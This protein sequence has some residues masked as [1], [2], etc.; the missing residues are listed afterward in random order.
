[1][2]RSQAVFFA[3]DVVSRP[4]CPVRLRPV[5]LAFPLTGDRP[6]P[7]PYGRFFFPA[8][9]PAGELSDRLVLGV[10]A[11]RAPG[12][13]V[14]PRW[15]S[16]SCSW[17]PGRGRSRAG[18]GALGDPSRDR[19]AGGSGAIAIL[20]PH[21][22]GVGYEATDL[23]PARAAQKPRPPG[24]PDRGEDGGHRPSSLGFGFGGG[25]FSPSLF[26]GAMTGGAF[27]GLIAGPAGRGLLSFPGIQ[28]RAM[29]QRGYIC[30]ERYLSTPWSGM[31]A[32]RRPRVL[33]RADLERS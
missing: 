33:G 22:L 10:S 20:F 2:R 29:A 16:S 14:G 1:M 24:R 15:R 31:G 13:G 8:F 32:V 4:L 21:V 11:P 28:P 30:M 19:R 23:C 17:S 9:V 18:Q 25:V 3:L 12:R 5:V 7:A 6:Q 26:L 27:G